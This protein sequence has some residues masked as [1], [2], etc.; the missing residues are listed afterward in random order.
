M[1]LS[2]GVGL[3]CLSLCG[4][5]V[6]GSGALI[7]CGPP[8]EARFQADTDPVDQMGDEGLDANVDTKK[9]RAFIEDAVA[10]LRDDELSAARELLKKAEPFADELKKEEIRS[11]RQTIDNAEADKYIPGIRKLAKSGKCEDAMETSGEIVDQKPGA[12]AAFVKKGTSR[13]LLDCFVGQLTVDLSI[14]RELAEAPR[15]KKVLAKDHL[16]KYRKAVTDATV[17]ALIDRF[18]APIAERKWVDAKKLLD[19]LVE[20]KE[21]GPREYNRL[22]GV[23]QEGIAKDVMERI[24][25]GLE[26]QTGA[27]DAL[28]EVDEL[29]EKGAWG[30]V[31]GSAVGAAVMPPEIATGRRQLALWTECARMRCSLDKPAEAWAYGDIG[32]HPALDAKGKAIETFKHATKLWTI[33]SSHGWALVTTKEPKGL[34]DKGDDDALAARDKVAKGWIKTKGIKRADTARLLPPGESIIGTRVWGPL[35]EGQKLYELG[36]VVGVKARDVVVERFADKQKVT[37]SRQKVRFGTLDK[38]TKV[39]ALCVHQVKME[40][41]RVQKV[42]KQP[43]GGALVTIQC[44]DP[45]GKPSRTK[46]ELIGS[47]RAEAREL[48]PRR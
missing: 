34:P 38:G 36:L 42:K 21:V 14:G 24:A 9:A 12:I 33:A 17:K 37:I 19:E 20:R 4:T 39:K 10:K 28:V 29:I 31:K 43:R 23:I 44:L 22:M 5:S 40:S 15:L 27:K 32:L 11:V 48:P 47:V 3:A 13:H 2:L 1:K 18:E 8:A 35:R 46:D 6:L 7:G 16:E 26:S 41:A 25:A 45:D 30:K